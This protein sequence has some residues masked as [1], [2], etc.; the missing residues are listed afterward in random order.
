[1]AIGIGFYHRGNLHV[2]T[3]YRLDSA[4]IVG[5][6]RPRYENVGTIR[7]GHYLLF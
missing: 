7:G 5:D 4:K 6:L 3:H 2:G 1:V